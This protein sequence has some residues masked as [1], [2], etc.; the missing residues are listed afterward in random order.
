MEMHEAVESLGGAAVSKRTLLSQWF[1]MNG[2]L[3]RDLLMRGIE[4]A[5]LWLK[6]KLA[7]CNSN[8]T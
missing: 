1:A 7:E 8:S 5:K 6:E 2:C 4:F 3:G